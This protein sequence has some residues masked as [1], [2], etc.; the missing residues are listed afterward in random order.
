LVSGLKKSGISANLTNSLTGRD[1]V[2]DFD[3]KDAISL[4]FFFPVG[5][6]F[7]ISAKNHTG[8]D[9]CNFFG[10]FA[11]LHSCLLFQFLLGSG[12]L[13]FRLLFAHRHSSIWAFTDSNNLDRIFL[14]VVVELGYCMC[15]LLFLSVGIFLV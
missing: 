8:S 11:Q 13:F 15:N 4:F 7:S 12:Q 3:A 1:L 5:F 9:V 2:I 10:A 14:L 6:S